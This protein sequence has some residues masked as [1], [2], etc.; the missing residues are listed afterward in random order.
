MCEIS[1]RS[2]MSLCG[3]LCGI[4]LLFPVIITTLVCIF[5]SIY[6]IIECYTII[7]YIIMN[8]LLWHVKNAMSR[9]LMTNSSYFMLLRS[10]YFSSVIDFLKFRKKELRFCLVFV[11]V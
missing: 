11:E 4:I 2:E 6:I 1:D 8:M 3:P 5:L 7:I 9:H 10:I